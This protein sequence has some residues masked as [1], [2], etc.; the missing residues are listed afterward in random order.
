MSEGSEIRSSPTGNK[1][2]PALMYPA[3]STPKSPNATFPHHTEAFLPTSVD[4]ENDT[5]EV[6]S[7]NGNLTITY[8]LR[9]LL[10]FGTYIQYPNISDL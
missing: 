3:M 1:N 9:P 2:P 8:F 4:A 5:L 6:V 7:N 10:I